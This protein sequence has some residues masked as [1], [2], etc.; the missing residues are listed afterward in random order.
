MTA[1]PRPRGPFVPTHRH[2]KGGEY[3]VLGRAVW[4]PDRTEAVIYDDA[5]GNVWV[6]PAA[7]F[8]DGRFTPLP[9]PRAG[10]LRGP[11]AGLRRG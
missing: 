8:D 11:F 9:A 3:R 2:R 5:E 6:R 1:L 10:W 4:E 7:E